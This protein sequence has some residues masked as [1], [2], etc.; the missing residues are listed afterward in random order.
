MKCRIYLDAELVVYE[1]GAM[2]AREGLCVNL[3][4]GDVCPIGSSTAYFPRVSLDEA[5]LQNNRNGGVFCALRVPGTIFVVEGTRHCSRRVPVNVPGGY[6]APY[7]ADT[8]GR[9]EAVF[10]EVR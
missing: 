3:F 8:R 1:K 7:P 4:R 2:A 10:N 9:E 5:V 6:S